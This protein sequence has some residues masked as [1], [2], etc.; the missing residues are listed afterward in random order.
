MIESDQIHRLPPDRTESI[1][2]VGEDGRHYYGHLFLIGA[3]RLRTL[4]HLAGLEWRTLH[5]VKAS[6][7]ALCLLPFAWPVMALATAWARRATRRRVEGWD[8]LPPEVAEELDAIAALNLDP[9][10]LL[11]KHLFVEFEKVGPAAVTA[12]PKPRELI[13]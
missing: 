10:V 6:G 1:W 8:R 5:P 11:G 3:Q 4:A 2:K 9:T 13:V 7:T 12:S